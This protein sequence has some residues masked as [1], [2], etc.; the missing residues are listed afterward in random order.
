MTF[1]KFRREVLGLNRSRNHK[2]KNSL[3][4]YDAF[5]YYRKS[6]PKDSKYILTES[7]YFSII[8][9]FNKLMGEELLKG[10]DVQFPLRMGGL[11]LRKRPTSIKLVD[12]KIK[13]TMPIDWN[14]TLKIWSEDEQSY[15][16]K[17]LVRFEEKEVFS[18]HY[19][20]K[21]CNYNNK[22][23]YQFNVNRDLK[24]RLKI[25]IKDNKIDAFNLWQTNN[26][27]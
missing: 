25:L 6:K 10:N 14:S 26:R 1:E 19:N 7:Q 13:N 8:R 27:V 17:Q 16:K 4:V 3:G 21:S 5:K 20:K 11:E 12:N 15:K 18:I 22:T 9:T 23:F 24:Q 2:V